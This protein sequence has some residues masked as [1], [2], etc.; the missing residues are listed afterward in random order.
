MFPR[1]A[2]GLKLFQKTIK[3]LKYM[4]LH[5]S[6]AITNVFCQT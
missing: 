5:L 2:I 6:T 4:C 1:K 3:Q